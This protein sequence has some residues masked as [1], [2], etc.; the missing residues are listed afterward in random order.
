MYVIDLVQGR[1]MQVMEGWSLHPSIPPSLHGGHMEACDAVV[2]RM[3]VLVPHTQARQS[4]ITLQGLQNFSHP[5]ILLIIFPVVP[6]LPA[7]PLAILLLPSLYQC[8]ESFSDTSAT[9]I[10]FLPACIPV[11][12][13]LMTGGLNY[14]MENAFSNSPISW[15]KRILIAA[16][17]KVFIAMVLCAGCPMRVEAQVHGSCL[18]VE[19]GS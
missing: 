1:V 7:I 17:Y 14:S 5:K 11:C 6:L 19:S 18:S 9:H 13:Q 12:T 8:S 10:L 4:S 15:P 3:D 16:A 2:V